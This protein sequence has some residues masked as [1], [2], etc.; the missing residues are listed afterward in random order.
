MVLTQEK[1]PGSA[2]ICDYFKNK[3]AAYVQ[4]APTPTQSRTPD[5]TSMSNL[6][7]AER[8]VVNICGNVEGQ[9]YAKSTH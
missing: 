3:H 7:P 5:S 1:Q 6:C 8:V 4:Y 9:I 2:G